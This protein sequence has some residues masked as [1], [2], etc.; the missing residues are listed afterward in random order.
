ML[1]NY[2]K[3]RKKEG[4]IKR[5]TREHVEGSDNLC[6]TGK[7]ESISCCDLRWRLN[8]NVISIFVISIG[9]YKT[10]KKKRNE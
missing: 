9:T 3:E 7:F 5:S 1:L 2:Y 4:S 8:H 10:E 6:L